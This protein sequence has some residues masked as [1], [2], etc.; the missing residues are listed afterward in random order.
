[1][2]DIRGTYVGYFSGT[3]LHS[4]LFVR[5]KYEVRERSDENF[6]LNFMQFL[7]EHEKSE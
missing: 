3:E 5:G 2:S 1:M 6:F 4:A 7:S